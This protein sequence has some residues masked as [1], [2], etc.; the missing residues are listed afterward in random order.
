MVQDLHDGRVPGQIEAGKVAHEQQRKRVG[1]SHT[2][3]LDELQP[4]LAWGAGRDAHQPS[5]QLQ[6]GAI[7]ATSSPCPAG[8]AMDL[9]IICGEP[10]NLY[11]DLGQ[12]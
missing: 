10:A 2:N 11:L 12:L 9:T 8:E 7:T 6:H 5:I 4:T 3:H 1:R